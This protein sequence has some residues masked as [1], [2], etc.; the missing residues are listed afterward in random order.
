MKHRDFL[1]AVFVACASACATD[2][3]SPEE[4]SA[5]DTP[6]TVSS[7]IGETIVRQKVRPGTA[8][9]ELHLT[10]PSRTRR[11]LQERLSGLLRTAGASPAPQD[12]TDAWLEAATTKI[13]RQARLSGPGWFATYLGHY[14]TLVVDRDVEWKW[15]AASVSQAQAEESARKLL[16]TAESE[17]LV[18]GDWVLARSEIAGGAEY[19]ERPFAMAYIFTFIGVYDQ[20]LLPHRRASFSF[21]GEGAVTR[22]EVA[23]VDFAAT[24]RSAT[25]TRTVNDAADIG[26][27][28][29]EAETHPYAPDI[30]I[31]N[32]SKP[33]AVYTLAAAEREG[34]VFPR[35]MLRW[36][37]RRGEAYTK[38]RASAVSLAD[39][40]GTTSLIAPHKRPIFCEEFAARKRVAQVSDAFY[41]VD[42]EWVDSFLDPRKPLSFCAPARLETD[43]SVAEPDADF[44]G[45]VGIQDGDSNFVVCRTDGTDCLPISDPESMLSAYNLFVDEAAISVRFDRN[46][47]GS[48]VTIARTDCSVADGEADCEL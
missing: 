20:F 18:D 6:R 23:S 29:L 47:V 11:D 21:N 15:G 33:L 38:S 1:L 26:L 3:D 35:A 2:S 40:H 31:H 14:D 24:G 42:G 39:G 48:S 25:A 46:G 7:S 32:L 27:A 37:S 44:L 8:L 17:G 16:R 36:N 4:P 30:E 12:D 45:A 41:A 43:G 10:R 9:P 5:L 28:N 22:I 19:G 34:N 13:Y